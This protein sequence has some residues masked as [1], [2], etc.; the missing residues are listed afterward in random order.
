MA[1]TIRII[2]NSKKF[3]RKNKQVMDM[4][5]GRMS[6]DIKQIAQ[7]RVPLK[8][9]DLHE[10]G[11]TE[12]KAPMKHKVWFGRKG[13]TGNYAAVQEKGKRRGAAAFTNYTTPGTGKDFLKNAGKK[14]SSKSLAYI[15]QAAKITGA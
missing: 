1:T 7:V 13:D 3:S 4:A 11:E 8:E 14:V 2:D 15:R 10:S 12:K 5:Y 6:K 9:G